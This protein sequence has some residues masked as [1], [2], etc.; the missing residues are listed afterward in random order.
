MQ[1]LE[2]ILEEDNIRM[3][4]VLVSETPATLCFGKDFTE[5]LETNKGSPQGDSTSSAFFKI[6]FKNAVRDLHSELK[7]NPNNERS[8][9]KVTFLPAEIT[10]ANDSDFPTQSQ[11]K[12][13]EI[14]TKINNGKMQ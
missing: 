12:S 5:S 11:V 9:S 7:N 2:L 8:Y 1:T 4:L 13:N 6:A 10:Y 14:K 3:C